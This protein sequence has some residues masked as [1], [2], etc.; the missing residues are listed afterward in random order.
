MTA[1]LPGHTAS[2]LSRVATPPL[3]AVDNLSLEYRTA[4]RGA[5]H[6]PGQ[7]RSRPADRFVLL[8]PS[9]CGKSTLLKAVAGFI[10]PAEGQILLQGQRC[11]ARAGPHRGVPGVRPAAAVENGEAERDVPLLVSGQLK[12]AEAEE[13]RCTT[14]KRSAWRR[15]PMP[16]HTLC[17]AA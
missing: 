6:P 4:Q 8:G 13:R 12:R 11:A 17:P 14:W 3:L 5:G 15:L 16:I 9:G 2:N 10:Q 1:P 7:L